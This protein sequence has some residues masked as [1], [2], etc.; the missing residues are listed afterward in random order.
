MAHA[1]FTPI[2]WA[3]RIEPEVIRRLY[4][5]DASGLIR[6]EFI[7]EVGYALL[8]RCETIRRVTERCCPKCGERMAGAYTSDEKDRAIRCTVCDFASTWRQYHASYKPDRVHGGRA[9]PCFLTYLK[10][11]P[12]CRTPQDK[13]LC[14]DRL[15]HA[16]H[17]SLGQVWTRPAAENLIRGKM[18]EIKALLNDLAYGDVKGTAREGIRQTYLANMQ[19]TEIASAPIKAALEEQF[20]LLQKQKGVP[21]KQPH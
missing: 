19:A 12:T 15:I 7:D 4:M 16:M 1:S 13:M 5:A 9:Y 3:P 2:T 14:I 6:P 18:T 8:A 10:E 20:I 17:V 21:E 11:F